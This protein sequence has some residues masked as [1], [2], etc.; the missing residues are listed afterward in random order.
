MTDDMGYFSVREWKY[1]N[2]NVQTLWNG[3]NDAD[4]N[5]FGF[6]IR[7]ISWEK[8]LKAYIMGIRVFLLK[9]ASEKEVKAY[10]RGLEE[11]GNTKL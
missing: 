1:C 9:N 6:S 2:E 10:Q 7:I 3:L 8:Y 4:K 11:D 5:I